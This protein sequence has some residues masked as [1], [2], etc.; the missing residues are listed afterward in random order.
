[1]CLLQQSSY[2]K[3]RRA[4]RHRNASMAT[5][6]KLL[7]RRGEMQMGF[8]ERVDTLLNSTELNEYNVSDKICLLLLICLSVLVYINM[9]SIWS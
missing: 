3:G 6:G 4:I 9:S 7:T 1:M 2:T 8:P 5:L